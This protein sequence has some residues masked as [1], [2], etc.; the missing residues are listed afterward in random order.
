MQHYKPPKQLGAS[1]EVNDS[2]DRQL[3]ELTA[4]EVERE[5]GS[6]RNTMESARCST[7]FQKT[8]NYE[9]DDLP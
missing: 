8:C 4:E 2:K 5:M 7:L 1:S 3:S 9:Q 6:T